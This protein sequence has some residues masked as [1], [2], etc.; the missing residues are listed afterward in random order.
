MRKAGCFI[1]L[2]IICLGLLLPAYGQ[3]V[4]D[5]FR[6]GYQNY[7]NGRY[8]E[9]IQSYDQALSLSPDLAEAYYWKARCYDQL[10]NRTE[11]VAN[12][13]QTLKLDPKHWGAKYTLASITRRL[14]ETQGQTMT[15][16]NVSLSFQ[17]TD[18]KQVIYMMARETGMN[19]VPG[20][21]LRG[22]ITLSLT[23]VSTAEALQAILETAHAKL[24]E[25]GNLVKVVP[26]GELFE[27]VEGED[28]IISKTYKI[29]YVKSENV[30]DALKNLLPEA[31]KIEAV[32]DS[33]YL[34]VQGDRAVIKKADAII[35]S[36]DAPPKQVV[37][38]AKVIEV[39]VTNNS[40]AGMDIKGS[41]VRNPND[42]VQ[43][44]GLAGRP[45]E[46]GAQGLYAQVLSG[47]ME[48]YV[49]ALTNKVGTNVIASPRITTLSDKPASILIGAKYGYKTAIIT[50]TSTTQQIQFLEVGTQLT[51]TPHVTKDGFIRM[52]VMPK[53]SDGQVINDL[54]QENTTET[55]NEVMVRDGQTIVIGGLI[56]DKEVQ[57]DIGIPFLMDIPFL[58]TIFR[59]TVTSIEK[60]ELLVFVTPHI[61]TP[62]TLNDMAKQISAMEERKRENKAELIH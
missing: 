8:E 15:P 46:T 26:L 19:L 20:Q 32:K 45:T 30:V 10:G 27:Y 34:V 51:I 7:I 18:V 49:S 56:K 2:G 25:S 11:A 21:D 55:A 54:P 41:Y 58:G 31:Q 17:D 47:N 29:D 16:G 53:V 6:Q 50:Q 40:N 48:A 1:G 61:L 52:S 13:K 23:D 44:I 43:T 62:E 33:S 14:P 42:I 12:L 36:L 37:V 5:L 3:T 4:E 28:G 9:S 39:R 35:G 24:I 59:K 57:T 60:S 38:E 22:R